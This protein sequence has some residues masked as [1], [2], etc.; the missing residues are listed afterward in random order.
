LRVGARKGT[1]AKTVTRALDLA[2]RREI[3]E[4][5]VELSLKPI[6]L[7]KNQPA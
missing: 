2:K 4:I 7:L 5:W 3:E 1:D 6:C